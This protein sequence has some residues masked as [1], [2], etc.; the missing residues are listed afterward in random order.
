MLTVASR[1]QQQYDGAANTNNLG[2]ASAAATSAH[3]T[4]SC[5]CRL[6]PHTRSNH[7]I[8]PADGAATAPVAAAAAQRGRRARCG[9]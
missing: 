7:R 6:S 4:A 1:S 2:S 9:G 8:A 3:A 5:R